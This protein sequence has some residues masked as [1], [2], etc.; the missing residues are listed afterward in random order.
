MLA[1]LRD[2]GRPRLVPICFAVDATADRL[3]LYSALDEKRKAIADPR[4]LARVRD[5]LERPPVSVLVDRWSEDWS[6]LAWLRL[7]GMAALLEPAGPGG[8]A[9]EHRRAVALLRARYAQYG[10]MDLER[11]PLIRIDV[12]RV[13]GWSAT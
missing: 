6:Q 4:R 5:I 1:T 13:S 7:D 2:D 10:A 8:A 9:S 11:G 3:C 12:E